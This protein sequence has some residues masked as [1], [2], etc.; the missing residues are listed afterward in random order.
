MLLIVITLCYTIQYLDRVKTNVLMPFIS[1]DIGLTAVEI[2][3]GSAIMLLFYGPS[4]LITGWIC[5]KIGSRKVLIFSIISWSLLTGWM[6]DMKTVTE[7]YIRMAIFG[8][9]VGTEFVPSARLVVRWFPPKM[10]ARAQSVLSWSWIITPAWA[11][12]LAAAMYQ[13][14]GNNW[15]MVFVILAIVGILPLLLII[16]TIYD[17]PEKCRFVSKEEVIEA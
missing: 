11:P 17:R 8:I 2:G 15:R 12:I 1:K 13:G 5:D 9:L 7:W 6:A 16:F 4:Q 3:L 10:R 14:L